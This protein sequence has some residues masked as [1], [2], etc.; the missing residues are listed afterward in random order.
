MVLGSGLRVVDYGWHKVPDERALIFNA[1]D[2]DE[3]EAL[4]EAA[5]NDNQHCAVC[6]EEDAPIQKLAACGH[7]LCDACLCNMVRSL[8]LLPRVL[9]RRYKMHSFRSRARASIL[10]SARRTPA[11]SK[12]P[13]GTWT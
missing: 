3:L 4:R 7:I 5:R 8:P 13:L 1:V 10:S 2:R 6:L 11:G 9:S 12:S